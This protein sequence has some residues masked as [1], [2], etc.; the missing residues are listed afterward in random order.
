MSVL[1][2]ACRGGPLAR[3]LGV[4][5]GALRRKYSG[6]SSSAGRPTA[7]SLCSS[8]SSRSR[9]SNKSSSSSYNKG[10]TKR[11]V[12][13][14]GLHPQVDARPLGPPSGASTRTQGPPNA[15][16]LMAGLIARADLLRP[17]AHYRISSSSSSNSSS[18]NSS[19]GEQAVA[20]VLQYAERHM[21]SFDP[22]HSATALLLLGRLHRQLGSAAAAAA[23]TVAA[24][25]AAVASLQQSSP[26]QQEL[27]LPSTL[28]PFL[29]C[30]YTNPTFISVRS[31]LLQHFQALGS[32]TS[33]SSTND[34]SSSNSSAGGRMTEARTTSGSVA[35][36]IS[37]CLWALG[38]LGACDVP[39]TLAALA[40]LRPLQQQQQPQL[41]PVDICTIAWGL[42][43]LID[44]A[45]VA[46][47]A[48]SP[49]RL[50]RM[51]HLQQHESQQQQQQ[52]Q[53]QL[54]SASAEALEALCLLA[55]QR[56]RSFEPR[57]LATLLW[58]VAKAGVYVHPTA[59]QERL[60]T[61]SVLCQRQRNNLR[62]VQQ[63]QQQQQQ[64]QQ[65]HVQQQLQQDIQ[66]QQQQMQLQQRESAELAAT[67]AASEGCACDLQQDLGAPSLCV[68]ESGRA[69]GSPR[70]VNLASE[71]L[72]RG[73]PISAGVPL[74]SA[75][76]FGA[77]FEQAVKALLLHSGEALRQLSPQQISNT[78]WACAAV[79]HVS[80]PLCA[81][82][83]KELLRRTE[84]LA[85]FLK[86]PS[87]GPLEALP[88]NGP[89]AADRRE[90]EGSKLEPSRQQRG[91]SALQEKTRRLSPP[92]CR[93]V[94]AAMLAASQLRLFPEAL[95]L[96]L[97]ML[98]LLLSRSS[99]SRCLA[100]ASLRDLAGLCIGM[101]R[102]AGA[103]APGALAALQMRAQGAPQQRR[104]LRSLAGKCL[105]D[106][107]SI[108]GVEEQQQQQQQQEQQQQQQWQAPALDAATAVWRAVA[109]EVRMRLTEG[110]PQSPKR[111]RPGGAETYAE[112][113]ALKDVWALTC[114]L[115]GVGQ[116][117]P[118]LQRLLTHLAL[119]V[120]LPRSSQQRGSTPQQQQQQLNSETVSPSTLRRGPPG[121]LQKEMPRAL[122]ES[123][124]YLVGFP[125][126]PPAFL[127][128]PLLLFVPL[129]IRGL[130]L[131]ML[132]TLVA[133]I[134]L[135]RVSSHLQVVYKPPYWLVNAAQRESRAPWGPPHSRATETPAWSSTGGSLPTALQLQRRASSKTGAP[136]DGP[137][138]EKLLNSGRP[139][140]LHLLLHARLTEGASPLL[141]GLSPGPQREAQQ[142]GLFTPTKLGGE[143][144]FPGA[145]HLHASSQFAQV[146]SDAAMSCGCTHRLDCE[147]SGP[148]GFWSV[149]APISTLKGTPPQNALFSLCD[150]KGKASQTSSSIQYTLVLAKLLTGRTHQIRVH[151]AALGH[152]H[153]MDYKY[154]SDIAA[155]VSD[156]EWCPRLFL[157]CCYLGWK[158]V[159]LDGDRRL[160]VPCPL[161]ADLTEA[162][163]TLDLRGSCDPRS[164]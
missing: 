55:T 70:C 156:R 109:R 1:F 93:D 9:S 20:R 59:A 134:A 2:Q 80:P 95:F 108:L 36:I 121:G 88:W 140:P 125:R 30:L 94:A 100:G 96:R 114:C 101:H 11:G 25:A 99:S 130:L 123:T 4:R 58:A 97:P 87:R 35:Q 21:D 160:Q 34:S 77:L 153:V 82:A 133:A 148:E 91:A 162:L 8:S 107:L 15:R 79:S 124:D 120:A 6:C 52:Q 138:S 19:R 142:R 128:L 49:R 68:F 71:G 127:P 32:R 164:S 84:A 126:V 122:Y 14:R 62:A 28:P 163:R 145:P 102:A 105:E 60:K 131:L 117:S 159:R 50:Q 155:Y 23:A 56:L 24:A 113:V 3:K 45:P 44:Q 115:A 90:R 146:L 75:G 135:L 157:H 43:T 83:A 103:A 67:A 61:F 158:D 110:L 37:N 42:A 26:Q 39:L 147:T 63:Q 66:Q 78:L 76:A 92:A 31:K 106:A 38:A 64:L 137:L 54:Q 154:Q 141:P 22:I 119:R 33:S 86:P 139:E 51:E 81:A 112:Q 104:L 57:G 47:I 69:P 18:S 46:L 132:L 41:L 129:A 10:S 29:R 161:P 27:L 85:D 149:S 13:K 143:Q 89:A 144:G 5:V 111:D 65:H 150:P 17:H 118:S 12:N 151:L 73:P 16:Q 48:A 53:Q 74:G 40:A 72:V 136:E 116:L 98:L 152:P 7:G